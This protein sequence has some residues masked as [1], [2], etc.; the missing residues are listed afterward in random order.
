MTDLIGQ[1]WTAGHAENGFPTKFGS[2]AP[3][4]LQSS[5][6]KARIVCQGPSDRQTINA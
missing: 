1:A 6:E 4:R 2:A 3:A 5:D